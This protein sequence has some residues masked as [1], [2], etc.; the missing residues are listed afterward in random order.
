MQLA[1]TEPMKIKDMDLFFSKFDVFEANHV[2]ADPKKKHTLNPIKPVAINK[3]KVSE[4]PK[5]III[6]VA[7]KLPIL[8]PM[9]MVAGETQVDK[10]IEAKRPIK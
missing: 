10:G 2:I 6:V 8:D 7:M 5:A 4:F 1:K 3:A 9:M